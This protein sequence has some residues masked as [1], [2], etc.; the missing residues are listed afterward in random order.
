MAC[1]YFGI[2]PTPARKKGGPAPSFADSLYLSAG[3]ALI[4]AALQ[5]GQ[6]LDGGAPE[7]F[8]AL[9]ASGAFFLVWRAGSEATRSQPSRGTALSVEVEHHT[10]GLPALLVP[11]H[12]LH[13]DYLDS[14]VASHTRI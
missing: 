10:A 5:Q 11:L 2:P 12:S 9:F 7:Y 8:N 14:T 6:R 3:L 4:F 13:H 1:I